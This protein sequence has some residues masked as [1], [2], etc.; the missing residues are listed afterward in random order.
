MGIPVMQVAIVCHKRTR[1]SNPNKPPMANAMMVAHRQA[2]AQKMQESDSLSKFNSLFYIHYFSTE[3]D[4]GI[5][6]GSQL[7]FDLSFA[8]P[9]TF[10][11]HADGH[12][13]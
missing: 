10:S 12:R 2:L 7:F 5:I 4:Y 9:Q 8:N 6:Q 11:P 1:Q 13:V 3:L